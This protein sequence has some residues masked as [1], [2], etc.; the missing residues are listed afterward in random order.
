[1]ADETDKTKIK[2]TISLSESD[3]L[4]DSFQYKLYYRVKGASANEYRQLLGT[5]TKGNNYTV[6]VTIQDLYEGTEYELKAVVDGVEKTVEVSTGQG[7]IT[8]VITL[9]P[10][11]F[12]AKMNAKLEF[13]ETPEA[14]DSY[15]VNVYAKEN[16]GSWGELKCK[17]QTGST[18]YNGI[19]LTNE[20]HYQGE[21]LVY[22]EHDMGAG[23]SYEIKVKISKN[24]TTVGEKYSAAMTVA[25]KDT[26]EFFDWNTSGSVYAKAYYR[27]K[28]SESEWKSNDG[29]IYLYKSG[30]GDVELKKL[31]PNTEYEVKIT[32]Y[33]DE[34]TIYGTTTFRTT[35]GTAQ[36]VF[37][38]MNVKFSGFHTNASGTY[39]PSD[40]AEQFE[41]YLVEKDNT[42]KVLAESKLG[43]SKNFYDRNSLL[44]ETSKG[45]HKAKHSE[46]DIFCIECSYRCFDISC[47]F[48]IYR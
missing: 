28:G 18:L 29:T 20:N 27:V 4:S 16:S 31:A 23:A 15:R 14:S 34:N 5:L 1:M 37:S 10:L 40:Y 26:D 44:M 32:S 7:S 42:G 35:E 24:T 17:P 22:D 9:S 11:S 39:T 47:G 43:T 45:I 38:G 46:C 19:E 21:W 30:S 6:Q 3:A 8:P 33:S 13:A 41:I 36:G 25:L 48:G 12:G 2:C